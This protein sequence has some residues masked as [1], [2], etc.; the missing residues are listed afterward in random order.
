MPLCLRLRSPGQFG[1]RGQRGEL[2]VCCGD[3]GLERGEELA[4]GGG[5]PAEIKVNSAVLQQAWTTRLQ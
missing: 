5:L 3:A 1:R 4:R 2:R